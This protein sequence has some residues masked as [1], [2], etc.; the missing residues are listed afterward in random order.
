MI[1][2]HDTEWALS[3]K[4]Y[5]NAYYDTFI[6]IASNKYLQVNIYYVNNVGWV[7]EPRNILP[8]F[9]L[10]VCFTKQQAIDLCYSMKW[11]IR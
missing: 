11:S 3:I 1:S 9:W 7:I 5:C 8:D 6:E 10:D 4:K 2:I